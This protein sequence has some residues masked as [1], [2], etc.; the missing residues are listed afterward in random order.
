MRNILATT[1]D[2]KNF[3]RYGIIVPIIS[4]PEFKALAEHTGK[5]GIGSVVHRVYYIRP[6]K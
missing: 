5:H 1:L 6:A 2:L 3:D 4:F